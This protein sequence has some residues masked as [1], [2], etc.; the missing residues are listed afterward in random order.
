[1]KNNKASYPETNMTRNSDTHDYPAESTHSDAEQLSL[2]ELLSRLSLP[3]S[4]LSLDN[5]NKPSL[6]TIRILAVADIDM[7]SAASLA[8]FSLR[9]EVGLGRGSVDLLIAC[10]PFSHDSVLTQYYQRHFK[11]QIQSSR[12]SPQ[13][14]TRE[15]TAALE[16]LMTGALSQLESIVCRVVFLP[17]PTDPRTTLTAPT[18]SSNRVS[19]DNEPPQPLRLTPNSRNI[20]QH[21]L[22]LAPGLG[23]AGSARVSPEAE[24]ENEST[25]CN[26]AESSRPVSDLIAEDHTNSLRRI[27]DLAPPCQAATSPKNAAAA[28]EISTREIPFESAVSQAILVTHG[29][30]T[31]L[32][33]KDSSPHSSTRTTSSPL[34]STTPIDPSHLEFLDSL[35]AQAQVIL[36]VVTSASPLQFQLQRGNIK[37]V[38]PG[39]LRQ[40]GDFA[41]IDVSLYGNTDG[42]SASAGPKHASAASSLVRPTTKTG[43]TGVRRQQYSW[44]VNAVQFR[45]MNRI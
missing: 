11:R 33:P 12:N 9:R 1:M 6:P 25:R 26:S 34:K 22:Q 30:S 31:S 40:N 17:H 42:F 37:V 32:E 21:W 24:E 19:P 10:G 41:I 4:V 15:E 18:T 3:R 14:R 36:D 13:Q 16:G 43:S 44:R 38:A 27:L 23:C 2:P 5:Q 29:P 45:N 20:H 35:Q 7:H 39:S 28:V 8:E